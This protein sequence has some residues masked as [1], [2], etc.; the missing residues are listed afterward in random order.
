MPRSR[1]G[2]LLGGRLVLVALAGMALGCSDERS[3]A[4]PGAADPLPPDAGVGADAPLD[5]SYLCGNRFLVTNA[6]TVPVSV[7]YRVVDT[8]ETGVVEVAAAMHLVIGSGPGGKVHFR[9]PTRVAGCDRWRILA[10]LFWPKATLKRR[11]CATVL[12]RNA[13]PFAMMPKKPAATEAYP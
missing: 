3:G 7:T 13:G 11:Q 6:R 1:P 8:G 9:D 4:G 10:S 5:L 12:A 2:C